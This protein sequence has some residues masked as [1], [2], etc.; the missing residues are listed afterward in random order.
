LTTA[1]LA[2]EFCPDS[3]I[4]AVAGIYVLGQGL[5]KVIADQVVDEHVPHPAA[6]W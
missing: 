5:G 1:Q 6:L 3:H 4:L 2:D